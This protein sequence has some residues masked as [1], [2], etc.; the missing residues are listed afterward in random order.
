MQH[1]LDA[2]DLQK[3]DELE[4]EEELREKA[5]LYDSE[6]SDDDEELKEVQQTALKLVVSTLLFS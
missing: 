3:L 6:M 2:L 4:K 5:G 1:V